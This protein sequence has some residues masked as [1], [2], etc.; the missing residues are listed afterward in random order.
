[1]EVLSAVLLC[2]ERHNKEH[3]SWQYP[4][5]KIPWRDYPVRDQSLVYPCVLHWFS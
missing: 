1:M 3:V 2:A 5:H 4:A